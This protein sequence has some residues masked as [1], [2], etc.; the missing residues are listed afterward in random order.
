[1]LTILPEITFYHVGTT[2]QQIVGGGADDAL[3]HYYAQ[4]LADGDAD[5]TTVWLR[6]EY[7][8][9]ATTAIA[10]LQPEHPQRRELHSLV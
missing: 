10:A 5:G 3:G 4:K 1:M 2:Y 8:V 6:D 9:D 7:D